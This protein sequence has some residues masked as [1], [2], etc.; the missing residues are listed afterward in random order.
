MDFTYEA[1]GGIQLFGCSSYTLTHL[2]Y[3]KYREGSILFSK[4]KAIKGVYEKI[5]I[6]K[7][8]FP[9]QYVN[10]YVDTFNGLWNEDELVSYQTA[11]SLVQNYIERRNAEYEESVRRCK[12]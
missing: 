6:K 8:L 9:T 10:L 4:Q 2:R 12:L 5:A 3:Y 11:V 1:T 7:V